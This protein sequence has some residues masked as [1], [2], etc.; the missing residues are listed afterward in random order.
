MKMEC[1]SCGSYARVPLS[2]RHWC[3]DCETEYADVSRRFSL[4]NNDDENQELQE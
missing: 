1:W 3:R 4:K 2:F